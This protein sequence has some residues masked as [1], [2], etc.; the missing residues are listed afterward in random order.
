MQRTW[1]I[2]KQGMYDPQFE[3][4]ACGIALLANIHGRR[5]HFIVSQA[6]MALE[7][8]NHRGGCHPDKTIGDGAGILTQIPHKFFRAEWKKA[9]ISLAGEGKYGVGMFFLPQQSKCRQICEALIEKTINAANL[10]IIGWRKVPVNDSHLH[11]QAKETQP[12]IKQIF[13]ESPYEESGDSKFERQLY[14]V[15]RKV[16]KAIKNIQ[17][18]LNNPFYAVSFSARTII[19][20]GL[21][22]PEQLKT[23][24]LDLNNPLYESA[25]AMVHN[26]FSTNTFPSWH[27]AQPHRFVMHNGEINTINGNV[28]GMKA[29]EA[30]FQTDLLEDLENLLPVIDKDGSDSSM[31]DN[32]LE[33]LVLSGWSLPH[34]MMMMIPEILEKNPFMDEEKKAF[35]QFHS[36]FMEPWEGPAAMAFTDGKIVGACLDRNGLRPAR[37]IVTEDDFICVSSETGVVD[38]PEEKIVCKDRLRPGQMLVID[39]EKGRFYDNEEIKQLIVS[40]RPYQK[41]VKEMI[42]PLEKIAENSKQPK[43]I[44]NEEIL[45]KQAIFGLYKQFWVNYYLKL[46]ITP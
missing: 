7:R 43:Q 9:G 46:K 14:E 19:Y 39:L 16:E 12:V 27:R 8:L 3:H 30:E 37:F 24:Y 32:A 5:D 10:K 28:N 22:L 6:L 21:L 36:G 1:I 23:Y 33:F 25:M 35:Y 17:L 26:R 38:I 45:H 44:S 34:A 11:Q 29:R 15:R 2:E 40:E 42:I 31:F 4:D 18:P 20:K 13:V 41:L